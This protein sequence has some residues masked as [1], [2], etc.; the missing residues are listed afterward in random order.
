MAEFPPSDEEDSGRDDDWTQVKIR[1]NRSTE[2]VAVI[3]ITISCDL[4][5]AIG[6]N[7]Y[8]I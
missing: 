5:I 2:V 6:Y 3:A 4:E 7:S 8:L 1:K